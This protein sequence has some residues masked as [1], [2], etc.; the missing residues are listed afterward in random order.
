MRKKRL[1]S[2]SDDE[3]PLINLTPLI[4]VVFVV[5][6]VFMILA[7]MLDRNRIVLANGETSTAESV[8][9]LEKKSPILIQVYNDNTIWLN[10]RKVTAKLLKPLLIEERGRHPDAIPLIFHDKNAFFGTYQDV[11]NAVEAAGFE[12]LDILLRPA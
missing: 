5:L 12:T 7:P 9:I 8:T 3:S 11:K 2:S 10:K 4:D 1:L 6:I